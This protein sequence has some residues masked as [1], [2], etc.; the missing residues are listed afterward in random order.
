MTAPRHLLAAGLGLLLAPAA[1]AQS[2]DLVIANGRVMDPETGFDAVANVGID[3]GFITAITNDAIEGARTIDATGHVVAP[4][5]IDGHSHGQDA[6]GHKLY[7]RDGVTTAMDLELGAFPVADYYDHW[8]G[9]AQLNYGVSVGHPWARMAVLDGVDSAGRG[10]YGRALADSLTDGAK[11]QTKTYDPLDE[12][13]ILGAVEQGL[14]EGGLGVGFAIGYYTAVGSPEIMATAGLAK[15]Y[16]AFITS[17]VRY[18]SQVPPS[19]FLGMQEMINVAQVQD[20]P[21]LL[22]HIPSNCVGL[23]EQCLDLIDAALASGVDVIGE[24]YPYNFAS[25][26]ANADYLGPGYQQQLGITGEDL[27]VIATGERLTDERFDE[28]RE[29]DPTT[30]LL[31]YSMK[32][33]DVLAAMTRPGIVFGSDGMPFIMDDG[34]EPGR[35]TAYG[36]GRGHP[37]GAGAHARFLRMVRED[38]PVTL[39]EALSKLSFELADFLEETVPQFRT[40]GRMQEG[41]VADITVFDP[42]TVT[43]NASWEEG[44]N[45]L[46]STG[47]PYVVVNGVVV[48]DGSEV[49]DVSPGVAIR[50]AVAD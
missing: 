9:R 45:T 47:I 46:P 4:G 25:T 20:V 17:H 21:L 16:G 28:V 42:E 14:K 6:F 41:M 7:L 37:R 11:W 18:L 10:F 29:T 30:F 35:D 34:A 40:R 13:D 12:P 50:R 15:A 19:G 36:E 33:E 22:H 48:V 32:D 44:E 26:Y 5:F 39:M 31:M 38:Q 1:S 8:D 43:D 49:Q 2:Y 3:N 27:V 23:T 24:F